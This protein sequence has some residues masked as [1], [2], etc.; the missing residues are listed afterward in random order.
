MFENHLSY[1]LTI[2]YQYNINHFSDFP[3][4][5]ELQSY[6]DNKHMRVTISIITYA[7]S[8]MHDNVKVSIRYCLDYMTVAFM[9]VTITFN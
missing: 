3:S 9:I 6:S 1:D 8:C 2:Y 5:I 4:K 7:P